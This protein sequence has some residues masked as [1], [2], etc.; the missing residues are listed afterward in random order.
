MIILYTLLGF[1]GGYVSARVYK[2]FGGEAWKR[3]ILFTPI[4]I[5]GVVFGT[6][7]LLNLF[8]VAK[9]SSGAVPFWTMLALVGI[10]F[11]ISLPLSF[12][13]SW[14]GFRAPVSC[15]N[16][17]FQGSVLIQGFRLSK[18]LC[19]QIRSHDR[20]LSKPYTSDHCPVCSLSVSCLLAPFSLS[21]TSS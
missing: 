15:S 9:Q 18:H 11:V 3:N 12:A 19:E 5:P 16:Q 13:G 4:F 2:T 10:W 14:F 7:F 21:F 20:Y 6:F 17:K 1:V 8:L